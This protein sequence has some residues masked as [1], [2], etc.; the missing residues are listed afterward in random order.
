M[1]LFAEAGEILLQR[2]RMRMNIMVE[3]LA[4]LVEVIEEEQAMTPI[5]RHQPMELVSDVS[6][7]GKY[8]ERFR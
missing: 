1:D 4:K 3:V 6:P 5:C 2:R 7:N 8:N